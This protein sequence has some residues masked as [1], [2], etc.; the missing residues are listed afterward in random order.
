MRSPRYTILIANQHSGTVRR[1]SLVRRPVI[2]GCLGL[3]M[4]PTLVGL[5]A[6]WATR[7]ELDALRVS[8]DT[9]RVE[10]DSYRTATGELASQISSLETAL[11]ELSDKAQIDPAARQAL[12]KLP[13]VLRSRAMGGSMASAGPVPGLGAQAPP[14]GTFSIL[15][16]LLGVMDERLKSVRSGVEARQALAAATPSIWP[17]AGWLSSAFGPRADPFTG[18][19]DFHPGLDISADR[20]TP[21]HA[22]ADGMVESA[23]YS[24]NYGNCILISHGF[25]ISTR[26][27]HLS[28]YAV[29]PGQKIKRGD[30]IG[31][32]GSTGRTTAPHLH[33]E[34]L[35]NGQ[36]INPLRLLTR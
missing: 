3:L 27:G 17:L 20:G 31:F 13:A 6:H 15:H 25:G 34:I 1:F 35:L 24:G 18:G 7:G 4:L 33:Y 9:L 32:V 30:V 29:R 36:P 14:D 2:L 12:E 26:F 23:A 11:T 8:N 21:V 22:T 16:D 19:P 5:G 10:N 28:A